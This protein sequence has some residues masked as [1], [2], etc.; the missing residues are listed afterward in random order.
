MPYG[1]WAQ[2]KRRI[3]QAQRS[4]AK[5][6]VIFGLGELSPDDAARRDYE[7]WLELHFSHIGV[8]G[9]RTPI[10]A[11]EGAEREVRR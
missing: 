4:G 11:R 6:P 3:K 8:L 1:G 2:W 10:S 9:N 5:Y 7:S